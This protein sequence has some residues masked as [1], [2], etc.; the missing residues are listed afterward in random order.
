[1]KTR[2]K[3]WTNS[4]L[5]KINLQKMGEEHPIFNINYDAIHPQKKML[6]CYLDYE[7]TTKELAQG[8]GHTNR[9]EMMQLL[10]LCIEKNFCIDVCGCNDV[11]AI[12]R[13]RE[14]YYDYILGFGKVFREAVKKN[15]GAKAI[16]Y[17]TENPY[18]RSFKQEMERLVYFKERTGRKYHLERT[19]EYYL[20][21]DEDLADAVICLGDEKFFSDPHQPVCRVWPSATKNEKFKLDF[22]K[23]KKNCF[24]VYG[25]DGFIHKGNDLLV[26]VFSKNP[27]WELFLCGARGEK[28][29]FECGYKLPDNVHAI[30]YVDTKSQQFLDIVGQ[31]CFLLLPSCSEGISTAVLTGMRH[32]VLPIVQK[33]IGLDDMSAFCRYFAGFR[34]EEIESAIG[35]ALQADIVQLQEQSRKM[36]KFA[37]DEFT[38]EQYQ[39]RIGLAFDRLGVK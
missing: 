33:D 21:G 8:I 15:S 9:Q 13:L 38:L 28:K 20:D 39:K 22:S 4:V 3:K 19:G 32:G 24:M 11:N 35:E 17:M 16:I 27:E 34:I 12:E 10:H 26:E 36:V 18:N 37:D 30:G 5:K 2:V 29:A 25:V 31:C 1:M 6:L 23:K 7:K 14:E